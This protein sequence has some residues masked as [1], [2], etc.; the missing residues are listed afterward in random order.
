MSRIS[1]NDSLIPSVLDRLTGAN[2]KGNYY[3]RDLK[4][5]VRRDMENLLN[6]RWRCKSFP[7]ETGELATSLVGYGIPDVTG[8]D[9][10]IGAN[11]DELRKRIERVIARFEPRFKVVKVIFIPST[12]EVDR[13]L[14][15]RIDAT[16]YAE[17]SP[18]P[19]VLDTSLDAATGT[20]DVKRA[21]S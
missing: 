8:F 10:G 14:R 9:T 5:A 2:P 15:F 19:I 3:L 6:T 7:D 20:F 17:P 1:S 18:E 4:Q 11:R 16:L 21:N 13:T 12:D